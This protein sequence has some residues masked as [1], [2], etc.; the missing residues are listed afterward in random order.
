MAHPAYLKEKAR[1]LRR[2]K[3]LTIDQLAEQLALP[4][5]TIYYWVRDLSINF[6]TRGRPFT[7]AERKKA[8]RALS[9]KYRLLR[10]AAYDEGLKWFAVFRDDKDFRDFIC[11]YIAEGYK[12]NRN[13]VSVGN[14]DPAVLRVSKRWI[15]RFACRQPDYG[16][17]Y[18]ADQ[19][20]KKLTE[21][22]GSVLGVP[23]EQIKLQRKSN[24][25][26]LA[27]RN[28]RSRYGVLTVGVNDTH[29]RSELQAWMDCV[30]DDWL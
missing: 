23:P 1:T 22:W 9:R 8:A 16:L 25:S 24:S 15:E 20:P 6:S 4:R 7:S 21:F 5:T 26:G 27:A 12:K 11:L 10:E 14:S 17:Q 3:R 2:Q 29:F 28:W 30:R 18:H 19:D 13:R